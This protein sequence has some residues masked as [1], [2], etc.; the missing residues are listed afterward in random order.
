MVRVLQLADDGMTYQETDFTA[1]ALMSKTIVLAEVMPALTC[2]RIKSDSLAYIVTANELTTPYIDGITLES[3]DIGS[4]VKVV[5]V[6]KTPITT[7]TT[8]PDTSIFWLNSVGGL[9]SP[10]PAG[11]TYG[12]IIGRSIA[13]TTTFIFD[14]QPSIKL[15]S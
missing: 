9:V 8:Y 6:S 12:I 11:I 7:N 13:G 3:G 2:F 15:A 10:R 5:T 14:P 4:E 1:D